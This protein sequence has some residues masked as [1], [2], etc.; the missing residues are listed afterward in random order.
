MDHGVYYMI[1]L[2]KY[3]DFYGSLGTY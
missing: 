1:T 3:G 2:S